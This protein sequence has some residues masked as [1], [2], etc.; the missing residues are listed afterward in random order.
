MRTVYWR[1]AVLAAC[2]TVVLAIVLKAPW[3]HALGTV[4]LF[5][6]KPT[7][8]AVA[9]YAL[10]LMSAFGGILRRGRIYGALAFVA[11]FAA[12]IGD[13]RFAVLFAAVA[14]WNLMERAPA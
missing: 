7:L 3:H 5:E 6:Q 14:A 12:A 8:L 1:C 4:P 13:A 10:V 2:C 9:I 11:S